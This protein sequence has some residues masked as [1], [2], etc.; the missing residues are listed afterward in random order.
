MM[1]LR[2]IVLAIMDGTDTKIKNDATVIRPNKN[3]PTAS[4][5]ENSA[6]IAANLPDDH[7]RIKSDASASLDTGQVQALT[8]IGN[9]LN[10]SNNSTGFE[11]ARQAANQALANKKIILNHRFVLDSILGSGG[12]GTVYKARDL[13]KVEANDANPYV[14]VKVLNENFQNHPDA[15]VTL[16][17]EASK[18][19]ILAHPNIVLVHD[20][21]R[22][23]DVIYMTMQLLDGKDLETIIKH[24]AGSGVKTESGL[25][26]INDFCQALVYAHQKNIIHSDLKP[27][28][29][30]V[31]NEGVKILD[32]GIARISVAA[33]GQN[34]FDAGSL[35]ALTPAYASLEM[36]N[37]D[38]PDQSDDVYAVGVIA[39]ELLTGK[40]PYAHKSA[41]LALQENLKPARIPGINSHQWH[42]IESALKLKRAERT[43]TVQQFLNQLNFVRKYVWLKVAAVLLLIVSGVL[44][45]YE[46]FAP[47]DLTTVANNTLAKATQCFDKQDYKCSLEGANAV[48]KM[49]PN[50]KQ[51]RKLYDQ[52]NLMQH[53]QD[54]TRLV[55]SADSCIEKN[56]F[57]CARANIASL[58][59]M[60]TTPTKLAELQQ[61]MDVKMASNEM[62]E[63]FDQQRYD[64]AL[65]K[66]AAVLH[67]DPANSAA[68]DISHRARDSMEQ[69]KVKS[70]NNTRSYTENIANA[71]SCFAKKDY[72][73]SMRLAKQALQ[74]KPGDINAETLYQKASYANIQ[75]GEALNKARGILEQGVT[76]YKQ[77]NYNC[78]IAKS[79]SALEFAPDYA[80][81]I[82]LKHDAQQEIVKLKNSIRI[83]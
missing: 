51:A 57:D 59:L 78:A 42:A 33:A 16:Q 30:F 77:K 82:K 71:E 40:H 28:N 83:E 76:C 74:Y 10:S 37:Q 73:C 64:C 27:G 62:R 44:G 60:S 61:R 12:M 35:G 38:P 34:S 47:N 58:R 5:G 67:V 36:I 66:S 50:N 43:P 53:Q 55:A 24:Q 68:L 3:T 22:D 11:K 25:K 19:Q 14:A 23:G 1:L 13:R 8:Q 31:T 7:T 65:E 21:D 6:Q 45:Y 72:E 75:K 20:F 26:I 46:F 29:I 81:A 32:F 56:D 70:A 4:G 52:S 15:F 49:E 69:N 17:R 48:L 80:E 54:E 63:C 2:H 41:D 9:A 39:Y 18:S 79:E